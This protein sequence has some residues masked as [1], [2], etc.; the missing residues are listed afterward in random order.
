MFTKLLRSFFNSSFLIF[1][2]TK[3]IVR[4]DK[5]T[6]LSDFLLLIAVLLLISHLWS[7]VTIFEVFS[8]LGGSAGFNEIS[9]FI[10]KI[11]VFDVLPLL[12]LSLLIFL[13]TKIKK[14]HKIIELAIAVWIPAVLVRIVMEGIPHVSRKVNYYPVKSFTIPQ[15]VTYVTGF[16]IVLLI[17]SQ[18]NM[19]K[20]L[21]PAGKTDP[22]FSWGWFVSVIIIGIVFHWAPLIKF[23]PLITK[24][25]EFSVPR[26]DG[27]TCSLKNEK[28][29]IVLLELWSARC[30][31]C[32]KQAK[33]LNKLAKDIDSSKVSIMSIHVSGGLASKDKVKS[34]FHNPKIQACL[35][36]R[37]IMKKFKTLPKHLKP[38][39]IPYMLI[40]GKNGGIRKVLRGYRKVKNLKRELNRFIY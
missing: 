15:L 4:S 31:Y 1:R 8:K 9:Y 12:I 3:E 35:G 26:I 7:I 21:K 25:P 37:E 20:K 38:S 17:I 13:T 19:G 16:L 40:I 6:I 33:E 11:M 23:Y 24:V 28:G 22:K 2:R 5:K 27:K 18:L 39:G 32:I 30:P 34:L 14:S 36:D 10:K 29:K